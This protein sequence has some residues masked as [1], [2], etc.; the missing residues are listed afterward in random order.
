MNIDYLG[1]STKRLNRSTYL[2]SLLVSMFL[3]VGLG[4]VLD[5]VIKAIFGI[6][7][8]DNEPTALLLI[9]ILGWWVYA[10]YCIIR[11]L[12]DLGMSSWWLISAFV[13]FLNLFIGLRLLFLRG[14]DKENRYGEPLKRVYILGLGL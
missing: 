12:H 3:F 13:P 11:R 9:F 4:L 14:T 8:V 10:I 6:E 7:T 2:L 5:A 1:L